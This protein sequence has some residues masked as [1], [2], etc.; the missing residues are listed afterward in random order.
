VSLADAL[1]GAQLQVR[2]LDG[3]ALDVPISTVITPGSAKVLR[4]EGMPISKTGGRGDLRIKFE[5][6]FPRQ[7]APEQKQQLRGLLAGAV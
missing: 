6:N 2:S 4:G 3:R 7:L 1:C 5:I